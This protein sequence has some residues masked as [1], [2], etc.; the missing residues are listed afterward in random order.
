[1]KLFL[2]ISILFIVFVKIT[3]NHDNKQ[4]GSANNSYRPSSQPTRN[5]NIKP[6][7]QPN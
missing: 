6:S 3:S 4:S 7:Q 2:Y 1:M 5:P